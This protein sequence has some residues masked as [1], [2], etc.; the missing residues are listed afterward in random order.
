MRERLKNKPAEEMI[1][2]V[3]SPCI[4]GDLEKSFYA[5]MD[6][7]FAHVLMLL[8]QKI[9][10]YEDAK[11]ILSA[12][13]ELKD[14][15]PGVIVKNIN[16]ED[17]YSNIEDYIVKKIGP[18]VGGQLHTARSRND[19]FGTVTRINSRSFLLKACSQINSLRECILELSKEN[20]STVMPGYTCMQ[21]AEPI[22]LGHYFVGHLSV[23]ERD[24]LRLEN[25]YKNLNQSPLGCAAMAATTFDIDRDFTSK[26][27]GFDGSS[28]NSLD[29]IASRDYILE[30][31]SGLTIFTIN[32]SRLCHDLYIWSTDEFSFIEVSDSV[33]MCSSIMPQKKNPVTFEHIKAK[34]AHLQGAFISA[35]SCL[36]N[37][38]FSQC[39]D[40]SV[41]S[42]RYFW[43]SFFEVEASIYLLIKTLGSMKINSN[44][45]L[46]RTRINFSTVSELSNSL[47]RESGLSNRL[48]HKIV[49]NVVAYIIDNHKNIEEINSELIANVSK[50]ILGEEIII[51]DEKIKLSLDPILN[52]KSRKVLG[53]PSPSEVTNQILRQEKIIE[54]DKS[55]ILN[56]NKKI[57]NSNDLLFKEVTS[58]F[59]N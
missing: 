41:E 38:P 49:A 1:K 58:I 46:D 40:S 52:V 25:A 31:L 17:L 16:S 45:M 3:F 22:T 19:L 20:I 35:S 57:I 33:A 15:G 39:R 28:K 4:E 2:Y 6:I 8:K 43:N 24:F 47:V 48:S 51:T 55:K 56:L 26:L 34:A 50:K 59:K 42:V 21:P 5:L 36:K 18:D 54:H 13:T 12:L 23:F 9:V 14:K 7:N 53:G 11:L 30:I 10:S 27:L 32:L 37:I 29:G 44:R